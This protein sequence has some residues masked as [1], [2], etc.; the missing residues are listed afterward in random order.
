M[1]LTKVLEKKEYVSELKDNYAKG[2]EEVDYSS[3]RLMNANADLNT[4]FLY[5]SLNIAHQYVDIQ[6]KYL[7]NF[8]IFSSTGLIIDSVKRNTE[9]WINT[10]QNADSVNIEGLKNARNL[11]KAMNRNFILYLQSLER[12]Y[13]YYDKVQSDYKEKG[14]PEEIQHMKR[15]DKPLIRKET[16]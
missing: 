11:L 16:S 9:V 13:D 15:E 5:G 7:Q 14:K 3:K 4:E 8:P 6:E 2:I 12:M 1:Y 10:V